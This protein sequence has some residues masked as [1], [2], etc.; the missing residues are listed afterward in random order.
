MRVGIGIATV[1]VAFLPATCAGAD[2]PKEMPF[3]RLAPREYVRGNTWN[4]CMSYG[5]AAHV[6]FREWACPHS[7]LA[8]A[9]AAADHFVRHRHYVAPRGPEP[10][11]VV[12]P[13]VL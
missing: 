8:A 9:V 5:H 1:A 12:D 11:V 6:F 2:E 10:E 7:E 3:A 13:A 4:G